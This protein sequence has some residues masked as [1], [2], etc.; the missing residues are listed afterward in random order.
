MSTRSRRLQSS[1]GLGLASIVI[2]SVLSTPSLLADAIPY[3]RGAIAPQ[4]PTY[5][6]TSGGVNVY[7]Y[8]RGDASYTDYVRIYDVNTGFSSGDFFNNQSTVLGANL[9]VGNARGQINAGDR[10]IFYVDSPEGLFASDSSYSADGI[11]HGYI[12]P[13]SGGLIGGMQVPSGI[14]V[15]L[16]DQLGGG[17][18][19]Y[20]DDE[21]VFTGI[22]DSSAGAPS[23]AAPEPNSL[24]LIGTGIFSL[25]GVVRRKLKVITT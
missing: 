20:Y 21:L 7:F 16:E 10:L 12:T 11:N 19:S 9:A 3:G 13:Y 8:G 5:A 2:F 1:S 6:P 24:W 14:F 22:S 15:G 25:A 4:V 23:A 17:N 18:Q